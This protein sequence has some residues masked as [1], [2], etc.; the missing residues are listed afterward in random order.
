MNL[1]PFA[2]PER[3]A[4]PEADITLYPALELPHPPAE[5]CEQLIEETP[6]QEEGIVVYGKY[7]LQP[8]LVQWYGDAGKSYTYSGVSHE[9]LP[10]TP[11]LQQ[12]RENV[13][14]VAQ[15]SF[16]SVLLNLYRN[17]RDSMGMHADDEPE[18]GKMPVIA[19]LSLGEERTLIFKH[20]RDKSLATVKVPMPSGSLL[21]MRGS[22]Q[23]NWKHGINKV[24]ARCE[25]RVNL[26]FR[27]ITDTFR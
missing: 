5:M 3:L 6:W 10:W 13:E 16:N 4:M 9:P 24:S 7:H 1:F 25:P 8:R 2:E 20:K 12:L 22:T 19:S 27:K 26:T 17:N 14:K 15:H 23:D 21:L 18:L 11:L